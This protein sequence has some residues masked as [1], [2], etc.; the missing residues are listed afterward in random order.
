MESLDYR[1]L[2]PYLLGRD[3]A[4]TAKQDEA[5]HLA[6]IVNDLI[7]TAPDYPLLSRVTGSTRLDETIAS[8]EAFR[9][10]LAEAAGS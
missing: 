6:A 4:G 5:D 1:Q 2:G 3:V 7:L 10:G 8:F 9:R